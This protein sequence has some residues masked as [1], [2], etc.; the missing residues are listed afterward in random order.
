MH[1]ICNSVHVSS[2]KENLFCTAVSVISEMIS[3]YPLLLIGGS[4][5]PC[6]VQ[7]PIFLPIDQSLSHGVTYLY[8]LRIHFLFSWPWYWLSI[9]PPSIPDPFQCKY[10]PFL[11]Q[12][13]WF[14]SH[15]YT[16]LLE[17]HMVL[18]SQQYLCINENLILSVVMEVFTSPNNSPSKNLFEISSM[19]EEYRTS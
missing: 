7:S 11:Y 12:T 6:L 5:S 3:H 15:L 4:T 16:G 10:F 1:K 19:E 9:F 14:S 17:V 2:V 13:H 8:R 18:C